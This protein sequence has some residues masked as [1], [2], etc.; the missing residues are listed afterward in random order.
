[1]RTHHH[2]SIAGITPDNFETSLS[3]ISHN[4]ADA[5]VSHMSPEARR[6]LCHFA[7]SLAIQFHL[8]D[9]IP[10]LA[11]TEQGKGIKFATASILSAA[12]LNLTTLLHISR[13]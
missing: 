5:I 12:G 4:T 1:M 7:V 9:H 11:K 6:K 3:S 13:S 2:I 8:A 10:F